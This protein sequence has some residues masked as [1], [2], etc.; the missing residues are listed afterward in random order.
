MCSTESL[1][2]SPSPQPCSQT[3]VGACY[4]EQVVCRWRRRSRLTTRIIV[5]A[6][7]A[8]ACID[9]TVACRFGYEALGFVAPA[10][11]QGGSGGGLA[12][13]GASTAAAAGSSSAGD[14]SSAPG[15][16]AGAGASSGAGALSD[17]GA[18]AAGEGGATAG[19]TGAAGG[20]AAGG[21][22]GAG[23]GG[24]NG[25]TCTPSADCACE[26]YAGHDYLFCSNTLP[27]LDARAQCQAAGM[28]LARVDSDAEN[29]WILN[30]C[31]ANDMLRKPNSYA[32]IGAS[33]AVQEGTWQWMDGS[34]FWIGDSTGNS[35][36][37]LYSNWRSSNPIISTS[38]NCAMMRPGGTWS[39]LG[40]DATV[41]SICKSP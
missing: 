18:S 12:Q 3:R 9:L 1:C 34:V 2:S 19:G 41:F 21:A 40:C 13:A 28:D 6:A 16:V 31:I 4:A 14:T 7:V 35:V 23:T 30:T 36:D 8:F 37:G 5:V 20:R 38:S 22:A 10:S 17:A 27:Q 11:N 25:G 29:T 39:N 15:G 26:S 24:S 32:Y 33:D